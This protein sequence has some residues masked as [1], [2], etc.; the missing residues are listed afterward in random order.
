MID[1]TPLSPVFLTIGPIQLH[2]YGLMYVFGFSFGYFLLP[3]IF[4]IRKLEVSRN[5]FDDLFFY[6]ILGGILGGRLFYVVF[7]NIAYYLE[8]PL[9]ILAVWE[10]GMASHGGLLG[11]A[12]ALFLVTRHHKIPFFRLTD[13][14]VIPVGIGLMLG[15]IGNFI[16]GELYGRITDVPWCMYFKNAEGCRHPSQLYAAFKDLTLFGILFSLR[17]TE[18]QPGIL[19]FLFLGLYSLFR[20]IVEFFREPDVQIGTLLFGFSEGQWISLVLLGIS[21]GMIGYLMKLKIKE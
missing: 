17:K 8:H 19:T 4:K 16:N 14:I 3:H 12:L 13:S 2:Y 11:A 10:G 20:F 7:Y 18:W 5:Q 15:R 6:G 9:K 21:L 1:F